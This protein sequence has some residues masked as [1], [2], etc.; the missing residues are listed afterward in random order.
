MNSSLKSDFLEDELEELEDK[1]LEE[2]FLEHKPKMQ[3]DGRSVFE[4]DR[5]QREKR[6]GDNVSPREDTA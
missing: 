1:L 5:I 2:D 6:S 4:I 3:V